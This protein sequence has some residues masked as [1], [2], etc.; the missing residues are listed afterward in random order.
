MNVEKDYTKKSRK[1]TLKAAPALPKAQK[2]TLYLLLCTRSQMRFSLEGI[3]GPEPG[4]N[5]PGPVQTQADIDSRL[6]YQI[7]TRFG[8]TYDHTSLADT[9]QLM[10]PSNTAPA[11]GGVTIDPVRIR[12]SIGFNTLYDPDTD[13]CPS[14]YSD[15]SGMKQITNDQ[16]NIIQLLSTLA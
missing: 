10:P 13:P 12:T 15:V 7:S 9:T 14:D 3:I 4:Q 6:D 16:K 2:I 8:N 1:P 5:A 11:S